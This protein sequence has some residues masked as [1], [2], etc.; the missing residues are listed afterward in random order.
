MQDSRAKA[1]LAVGAAIISAAPVLARVVA[2]APTASAFWRMAVGGAV[3]AALVAARRG[4]WPKGPVMRLAVLA[5]LC[6]ALDLAAL[7]RAVVMAGP[8]LAILLGNGQAFLL[9]A[10]G[11]L[12]MGERVGWR[13]LTGLPVAVGGL[14]LILGGDPASADPVWREGVAWGVSTSF[15]Y[16]GYLILLRAARAA[17]NATGDEGEGAVVAVASVAAAAGLGGLALVEGASL[18]VET[19]QDTWAIVGLGFGVQALGWTVIGGALPR[20]PASRAGVILLLQPG[21]AF[22]WDV[23]GFG[24]VVGPLDAVGLA[25]VLLG[26][27]LA[28]QPAAASA[29]PVDQSDEPPKPVRPA[30]TAAGRARRRRVA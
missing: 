6:F 24:R 5:G 23:L 12:A 11:V 27:G 20:V 15:L 30:G 18:A 17:A 8:G 26:V 3:L 4:R 10:F 9:A 19:W 7:H 29:P 22:L 21:L 25:L 13:L 1:R 28:S 16:A 14:A 2:L